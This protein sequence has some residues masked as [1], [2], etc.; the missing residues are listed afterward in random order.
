MFST[1]ALLGLDL[2]QG[3]MKRVPYSGRGAS[4]LVVTGLPND[5]LHLPNIP[6]SHCFFLK[7]L[8]GRRP[9]FGINTWHRF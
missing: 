3:S 8:L 2:T 4:L 9:R 1:V 7:K 6:T 5:P